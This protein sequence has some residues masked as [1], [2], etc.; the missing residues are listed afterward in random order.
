SFSESWYEEM[1]IQW[2]R[3][4]KEGVQD[5][6][7]QYLL[8]WFGSKEVSCITKTDVL[9]FRTSLG[10]VNKRSGKQLSASRINHIM[11]P[12]RMILNEAANRF[13]FSSPY[14]GI[15]S[16]KVPRTDVEPFTLD[17]VMLI[18]RSVRPDFKNYFTVRFFTA[19]R[20]SEIDGLQWQYVDFE[21]R[22]ILIRQALVLDEL[23]YTKNDGSYRAIDMSEMVYVALKEQFEA[24]GQNDF[25]F[26]NTKGG[27]LSHR[28]ITKRVWHPLLKLL[29]LRARRPYQTRH[30]AATLW[31]A[32]GESPE[33]IARQMGH[34]T[35]EMLFRTYSRYIPNLTRQ[36]G[37]AFERLLAQHQ[38]K[39]SKNV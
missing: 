27:T 3:T 30:T 31:L 22:Q 9:A 8:D 21:R 38:A 11:T 19:I 37:S 24:T 7:D 28:N 39:E 15:K 6:L 29:G 23:V 32:A 1:K 26:C 2:R 34:T 17:E 33:W 10:K 4:H 36:D 12:L 25:V 5:I 14:H 35:S 20:T 16:L 13:Q 18:L